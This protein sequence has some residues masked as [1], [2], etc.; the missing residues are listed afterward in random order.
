MLRGRPAR[1]ESC[2]PF[3]E[4]LPVGE[5]I[6]LKSWLS[7]GRILGRVPAARQRGN[8]SKLKYESQREQAQ[9]RYNAY[10]FASSSPVW[11]RRLPPWTQGARDLIRLPICTVH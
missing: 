6:G 7:L 5:P 9:V 1:V 2:P 11:R 10:H 8:C 4:F 3:R